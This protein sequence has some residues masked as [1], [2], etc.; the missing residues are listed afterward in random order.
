[1]FISKDLSLY[2][3]Y[4]P[5]YRTPGSIYHCRFSLNPSPSGFRLTVDWMFEA[6][7]E[8][9]VK[10]HKRE[11]LIYAYVIMANHTHIVV[12][13]GRNPFGATPPRPSGLTALKY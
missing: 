10:D 3:Q 9:T 1:M 13:P 5:H 2:Q 8:A 4:L 7:D 11:C 6:V 12:R